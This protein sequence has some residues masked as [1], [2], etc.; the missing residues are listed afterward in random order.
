VENITEELHDYRRTEEHSFETLESARK[1]KLTGK[2]AEQL[3]S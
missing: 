2:Q 1:I 3:T